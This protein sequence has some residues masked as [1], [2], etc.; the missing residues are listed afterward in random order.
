MSPDDH[1]G[2]GNGDGDSV[3]DFLD[4]SDWG[5]PP[6]SATVRVVFGAKS[7]RGRLRS[8][9]DDNYLIIRM[10]RHQETVVTSLPDEV[11]RDR[12][13]E[14][15]YAMVVADG[16]QRSGDGETASHVAIATLVG[17]VRHLGR[18]NVRVDDLIAEDILARAERF[19]RHVHSAVT[20]E[21]HKDATRSDQTTLTAAFSGGHDLFFAHVG[22]SRAY[23]FRGGRLMRLTRDHTVAG[24]HAAAAPVG[25]LIDMNAA[26]RD[27][28][29]VLTNTIGMA[30]PLKIDLERL[31]LDDNDRVLVCTNGV[32]NVL[33]DDQMAA[34]LS[35]EQLPDD[36]CQA[37]I[38]LVEA[39]EGEDD[40]TALIA[41]YRI[42]E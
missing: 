41:H 22:H 38:D 29:H 34:V 10:G 16:M 35:S 17:L 1:G 31:R 15:G 23:L 3:Q 6:R 13:D 14:Y 32:S 39:A 33:D 12:F 26:A 20:H 37:L 30:G 11:I 40:A 8:I 4:R 21:H 7:T 36:Q 9:N 27:L 19:Y 2:H 24:R 28:K 5:F 25:P 18:W 42:P